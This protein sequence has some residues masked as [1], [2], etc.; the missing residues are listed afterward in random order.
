[1]KVWDPSCPHKWPS[2]PL[3]HWKAPVGKVA[4]V[5]FEGTEWERKWTKPRMKAYMIT[6]T[7]TMWALSYQ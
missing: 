6:E 7:D 1:V 4:S 5:V 3:F 2:Y